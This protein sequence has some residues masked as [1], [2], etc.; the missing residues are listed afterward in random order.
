MLRLLIDGVY[1]ESVEKNA[2]IIR[3]EALSLEKKVKQM[4]YLNTLDYVLE[5]N[6]EN[7][8]IKFASLTYPHNK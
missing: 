1:V 8:E 5:N 4:L 3:D 7:I 2:E 6:F